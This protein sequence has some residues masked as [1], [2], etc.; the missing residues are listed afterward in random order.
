M[1]RSIDVMRL[2]ITAGEPARLIY[3]NHQKLTCVPGVDQS[4]DM[5]PPLT[6]HLTGEKAHMRKAQYVASAIVSVAAM[7]GC[8]STGG[9]ESSELTDHNGAAQGVSPEL[10]NPLPHHMPTNANFA[11]HFAG[12]GGA[13]GSLINHGGPTITNAHVVAIFWGPSWSSG[14]A[15]ST[16]LTNFISKYGTSGEYNTITQYSGI[17]LSSLGTDTP[18]VWFDASQPPTNATDAIVQ[19]EVSKFISQYGFDAS[20]IYEVFLPK[21]VYSSDGTSTSCGG[22]NLKYCA[23]HGN[24]T[25]SAGDVRYASMPY[26]SCGGCQTAGFTDAQNFEHFISHETREAVTDPDGSGWYD[27]R[28]YE[29]DDKCAW[30]PTPFTDSSVG[31]NVDGSGFA[32]QYEWSNANGGCVKTR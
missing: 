17:K 31:T 8:S 12:G 28:G 5:R 21:G 10:N 18:S 23:Y 1:T 20:A 6:L 22:T 26:P 11:E 25:S 7:V 16:S 24:F 15:L 29:A 4:D 3:I 19:A 30:S 14:D 9:V 32:Y 27:R 2:E 13:G